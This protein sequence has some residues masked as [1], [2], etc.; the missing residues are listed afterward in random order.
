MME[1]TCCITGHRKIPLDKLAYVEVELRKAVMAAVADGYTR[2]INGGA[3]GAD[4]L[5]A[6]IVAELKEQ[7]HSLYLEA[8]LPYSD[9][10]KSKDQ[11]FQKMLAACDAV[12]VFSERYNR[13]CYFIRNRYM[14]DES[15]RVIAVYD[16]RNSGG[17]VFTM[18][19]AHGKG[20]NIQVIKII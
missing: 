18:R 9:R 16:G 8:A 15:S 11:S 5:F 19:Y 14:V 6:A 1:S 3:A 2:F 13:G 7:G 17:T 4:L 12:K 10:K 20:R